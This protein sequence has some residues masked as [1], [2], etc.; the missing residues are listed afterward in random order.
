MGPRS[1]NPKIRKPEKPDPNANGYPNAQAYVELEQTAT[2]R[3]CEVVYLKK[4]NKN[5][6]FSDPKK[7]ELIFLRQKKY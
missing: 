2:Y 7:K 6:F 3:A 5:C 1:V 4:E